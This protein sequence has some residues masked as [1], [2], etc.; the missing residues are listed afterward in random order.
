MIVMIVFKNKD[1]ITDAAPVIILKRKPDA[2][3]I[4][5]PID[6]IRTEKISPASGPG[7]ASSPSSLSAAASKNGKTTSVNS[8]GRASAV[9]FIPSTI[10]PPAAPNKIPMIMKNSTTTG[11]QIKG[12]F[13]CVFSDSIQIGRFKIQAM[14]AQ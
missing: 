9:S 10:L 8:D 5:F 13:R 2:A 12:L 11:M 3:V 6:C 1:G 7:T 14:I 4:P